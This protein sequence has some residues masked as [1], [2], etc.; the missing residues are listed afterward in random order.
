MFAPIIYISMST[1]AW[2]SFLREVNAV[3]V[4]KGLCF[5]KIQWNPVP[6]KV[7]LKTVISTNKVLIF[8]WSFAQV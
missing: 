4:T 6:Q 3:W 5:A 1:G 8:G 2:A 7:T